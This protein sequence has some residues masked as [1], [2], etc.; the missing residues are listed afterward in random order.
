M[1][2]KNNPNNLFPCNIRMLKY[3]KP[4]RLHKQLLSIIGNS[5]LYCQCDHKSLNC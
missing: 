4:S 2:P 1:F 3:K 5:L